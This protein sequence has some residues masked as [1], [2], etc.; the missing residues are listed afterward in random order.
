MQT[1]ELIEKIRKRK[2][3]SLK[4]QKNNDKKKLPENYK[5]YVN[6]L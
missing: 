2:F 6:I 5:S 3:A 1:I 4:V